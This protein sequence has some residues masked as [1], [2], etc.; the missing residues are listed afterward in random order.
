[1]KLQLYN[2]IRQSQTICRVRGSLDDNSA[3]VVVR[4]T[5]SEYTNQEN[6]S[7]QCIPCWISGDG[8]Y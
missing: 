2:E 4:V 1:M 7:T 8:N 6:I 5:C 3:Q